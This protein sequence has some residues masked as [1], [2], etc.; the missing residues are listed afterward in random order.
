MT[1][2]YKKFIEFPSCKRRRVQAD[3]SGGDVTSEGGSLLLRQVDRRLG[4]TA[5]VS[6]ALIDS[7]RT[8]PGRLDRLQ[9][10]PRHAINNGGKGEFA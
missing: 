1:E 8:T 7:R 9:C 4:L 2:C 5:A 6:K 3:F 10:C